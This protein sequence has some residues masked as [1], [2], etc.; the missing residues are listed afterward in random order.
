MTDEQ[1]MADAIE[2]RQFLRTMIYT[3]RWRPTRAWLLG[4]VAFRQE[5]VQ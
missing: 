5:D 4:N 2:R 1:A 3:P